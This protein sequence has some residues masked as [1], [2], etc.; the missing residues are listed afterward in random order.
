MPLG[1]IVSLRVLPVGPSYQLL[2]DRDQESFILGF[3]PSLCEGL[4]HNCVQQIFG[5]SFGK[6]KDPVFGDP[7]APLTIEAR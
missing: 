6:R 2:K 4:T 7:A 3:I 1:F 5:E